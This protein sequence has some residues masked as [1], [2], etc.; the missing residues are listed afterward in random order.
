MTLDEQLSEIK[1]RLISIESLIIN[2]FATNTRFESIVNQV[3]TQYE[4]RNVA[5]PDSK[6]PVPD[7]AGLPQAPSGADVQAAGTQGADKAGDT[8]DATGISAGDVAKDENAT[9]RAK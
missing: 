2:A 5:G 9:D 8:G 4:N 6:V 1:D 7:N 3:R